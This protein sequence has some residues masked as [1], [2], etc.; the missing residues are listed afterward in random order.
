MDSVAGVV[1]MIVCGDGK[2][3]FQFEI[4]ELKIAPAKLIIATSMGTVCVV[5]FNA[6][7][8]IQVK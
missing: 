5:S 2:M 3:S 7:A 6:L 1:G 8:E 4:S